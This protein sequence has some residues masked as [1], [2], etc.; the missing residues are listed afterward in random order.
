MAGYP[1]TDKVWESALSLPIYPSLHPNE[2]EQIITKF[3]NVL[4]SESGR[5]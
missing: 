2:V 3:I 1:V 4:E 5:Q